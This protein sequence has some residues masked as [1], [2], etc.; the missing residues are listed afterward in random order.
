MGGFL[1]HY[2]YYPQNLATGVNR[3]ANHRLET[4][5]HHTG[6]G[7]GVG[8]I[9]ICH[10]VLALFQGFAGQILL[11][12]KQIGPVVVVSPSG[13]NQTQ[14]FPGVIHGP[15]CRQVRFA[16]PGEGAENAL[17]LLFKTPILSED[18]HHLE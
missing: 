2:A 6:V 11:D 17:A 9:V 14:E 10:L 3:E 18:S 16:K 15:Q 13:G 1:R 5:G 4:L 7:L 8:R 12:G